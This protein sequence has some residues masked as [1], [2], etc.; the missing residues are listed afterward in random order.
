MNKYKLLKPVRAVFMLNAY[1][2]ESVLKA[3]KICDPN[4][5]VDGLLNILQ[6]KQLENT[7]SE[8]DQIVADIRNVS[9]DDDDET[10]HA[11]T[12]SE[13]RT[14]E[15]YQRLLK[16]EIEINQLLDERMC[17]KCCNYEAN[18]IVLPCKHISICHRCVL[19]TPKICLKCNARYAGSF[20]VFWP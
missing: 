10:P 11:D 4:I 16:I 17:K 9:I 6:N 12:H 1:S 20:H 19:N 3:C 13:I 7:S 2:E 5:T 8:E 14:H 15:A 18:V